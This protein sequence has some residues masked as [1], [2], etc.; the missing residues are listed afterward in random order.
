MRRAWYQPAAVGG[1]GGGC[2]GDS[3]GVMIAGAAAGLALGI[4]SLMVLEIFVMRRLSLGYEEQ[5]QKQSAG[6]VKVYLI[7]LALC[8]LSFVA[9]TAMGF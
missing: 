2:A 5:E 6:C 8:C 1:D 9:L 7:M 3:G 4:F